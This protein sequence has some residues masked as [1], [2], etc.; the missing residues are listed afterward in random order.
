MSKEV[1]FNNS[2]QNSPWIPHQV[3]T[4]KERSHLFYDTY[5]GKSGMV[6]YIKD[7]VSTEF[8]HPLA[9]YSQSYELIRDTIPDRKDIIN[10]RRVKA[11]MPK[12]VSERI[13]NS[14][15]EVK[16]GKSK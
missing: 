1:G 2:I 7:S 8:P 15:K 6:S 4:P 14:L 12:I 13:K 16:G 11:E 10:D 9:R 5:K 3:F